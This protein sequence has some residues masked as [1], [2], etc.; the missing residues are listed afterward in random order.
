M[1]LAK[2]E[3]KGQSL[4]QVRGLDV[5]GQGTQYSSNLTL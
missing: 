4:W 3:L 2:G 1:V 5:L